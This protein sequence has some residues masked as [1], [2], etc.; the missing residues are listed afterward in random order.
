MLLWLLLRLLILRL[1]AG[2]VVES[3]V[4]AANLPLLDVALHA[5][6]LRALLRLIEWAHRTSGSEIEL[7]N[8]SGIRRRH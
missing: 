4:I 3:E 2:P 6:L 1:V 7:H 8:L 5:A